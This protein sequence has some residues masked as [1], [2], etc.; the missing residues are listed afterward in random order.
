MTKTSSPD[1]LALVNFSRYCGVVFQG[2]DR[3][4]NYTVSL[5]GKSHNYKVLNVLEFNSKRKRMSVILRSPENKIIILTK[6]ADSIVAQR[7]KP[8]QEADL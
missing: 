1:E 3:E 7:L 8:G 5:E 6:G 2:M 4:D